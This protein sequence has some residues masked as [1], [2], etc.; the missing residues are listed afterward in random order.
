M[1][2]IAEMGISIVDSDEEAEEAITGDETAFKPDLS[3]FDFTDNPE[4]SEEEI[5]FKSRIR[6]P[7][8]D[9]SGIDTIS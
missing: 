5:S 3:D 8:I 4:E 1:T 2:M 9:P 7:G 6:L